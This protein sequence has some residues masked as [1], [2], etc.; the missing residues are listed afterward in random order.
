MGCERFLPY[1]KSVFFFLVGQLLKETKR[2]PNDLCMVSFPPQVFI[3]CTHYNKA[4][5]VH[6]YEELTYSFLE[7]NV[8]YLSFLWHFSNSFALQVFTI[9]A[10]DDV[11]RLSAIQNQ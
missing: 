6:H 2:G 4:T 11:P 3:S 10:G 9:A 1:K 8:T 5:M 7:K